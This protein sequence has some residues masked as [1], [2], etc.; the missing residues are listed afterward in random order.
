MQCKYEFSCVCFPFQVHYGENVH[1]GHCMLK[2]IFVI[3]V[4]LRNVFI[5]IDVTLVWNNIGWTIYDDS[6]TTEKNAFWQNT[7][8]VQVKC[9]CHYMAILRKLLHFINFK[10]NCCTVIYGMENLSKVILIMMFAH[11]IELHSH[12]VYF[13]SSN[14]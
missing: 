3:I 7:D 1:C 5:I 9:L 11:Q 13:T 8:I 10:M 14:N 4:I 2:F 12:S 6:Y